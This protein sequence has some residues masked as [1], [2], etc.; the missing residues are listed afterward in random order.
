VNTTYP[1]VHGGA[2]AEIHARAPLL[3]DEH[4][5]DPPAK[6]ASLLGRIL[7]EPYDP[8]RPLAAQLAPNPCADDLI[9][10]EPRPLEAEVEDA[11]RLSSPADGRS[12]ASHRYYRFQVL[13]RSEKAATSA[14]AECCAE[15]SCGAGYVRGLSFAEGEIALARPTAPGGHANVAL[16][17]DGHPL[18]LTLLERHAARGYF[19]FSLA[20]PGAT[21]REE[22]AERPPSAAYEQD[23]LEVRDSPHNPDLFQVCSRS[24][25]ITENQL[26]RRYRKRTGSHELDDFERDRWA[27]VRWLGASVSG[28]LGALFTT[29]GAVK[30][31]TAEEE[32]TQ[33]KRDDAKIGGGIAVGAGIAVLTMGVSFLVAPSE[34]VTIEHYLTKSQTR[35]FVERYNRALRKDQ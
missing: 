12:P 8:A 21:P 20:A 10:V 13:Q 35:R 27:S 9:D 33:T 5:L 24:E 22:R 11:A 28:G 31:A 17:D 6:D 14:Y 23:R 15:A 34:G 30:I 19:A 4:L 26:V 18:E 29:L 2:F 3:A 7:L 32:S 1:S 25:C 16:D